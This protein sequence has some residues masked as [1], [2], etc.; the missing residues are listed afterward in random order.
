MTRIARMN[1]SFICPQI[2]RMD[3]DFLLLASCP[4]DADG[5]IPPSR[6]H[7]DKF[8]ALGEASSVRRA[9]PYAERHK[10]VGLAFLLFSFFTFTFPLSPFLL[11]PFTFLLFPFIFLLLASIVVRARPGSVLPRRY[12]AFPSPPPCRGGRRPGR[13]ARCGRCSGRRVPIPG[14]RRPASRFST[15]PGR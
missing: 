9:L 10:A 14:F 8:P 13:A 3:A 15:H 11:F 6:L 2:A 12:I 4:I 1:A 5:Y 7:R